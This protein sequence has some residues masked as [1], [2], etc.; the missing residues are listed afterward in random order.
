LALFFQIRRRPERGRRI[1]ADKRGYLLFV[2]PAKA[3]IH[4]QSA[5]RS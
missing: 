4:T 2:I 3:G 1:Y 5:E